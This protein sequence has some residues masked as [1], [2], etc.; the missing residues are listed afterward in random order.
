MSLDK[1]SQFFI[2]EHPSETAKILERNNVDEVVAFNAL[3]DHEHVAKIF[4]YMS[5]ELT[6]NCLIATKNEDAAKILEY[7]EV[8]IAARYLGKMPGEKRASILNEMNNTV[9]HRLRQVLKY[10][11]GTIGQYMSPN[12]YIAS[13][14][15]TVQE[16]IDTVRKTE[17]ELLSEVFVIDESHILCGVVDIKK[18]LLA[19]PASMV[20]QHMVC[21]D[22]VLNVRTN[23][24]YAK[25]NPIWRYK[26]ILPVT[27]Q[28]NIFV[29][30][31][32]RSTL[33]EK[34]S[35]DHQD[36]NEA[37][38]METVV[39]VAD[40]FWEICSNIIFPKSE[41]NTKGRSNDRD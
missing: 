14:E 22:V 10:P 18:L 35:N 8:E 6:L 40:L 37:P 29:G 26:E 19:D 25:N 20:S 15:M 5:P 17:S 7:F 3:L 39:E 12:I 27:D 24:E 28:K 36:K 11:A 32:K 30:V 21:P 9:S 4:K 16:V 38:L 41:S 34:I 2:Q 1:L 23:L 31:L 33:V 13:R